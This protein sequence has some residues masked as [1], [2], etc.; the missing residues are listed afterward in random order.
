MVESWNLCETHFGKVKCSDSVEGCGVGAH[1]S[2]VG[3]VHTPPSFEV[4]DARSIPYRFLLIA[5]LALCGV[6]GD[7]PAWARL[8]TRPDHLLW[9]LQLAVAGMSRA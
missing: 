6:E 7:R 2:A 5:V 8:S 3:S 4:C 1:G 9:V